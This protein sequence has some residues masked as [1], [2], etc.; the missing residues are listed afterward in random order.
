MSNPS[1]APRESTIA[2]DF[3]K[4]MPDAFCPFMY[5]A[6]AEG[7]ERNAWQ[8]HCDG[9]RDPG[10][11]QKRTD[12][13]D[14]T[15]EEPFSLPREWVC[16]KE[17]GATT[18][19]IFALAKGGRLSTRPRTALARDILNV[20]YALLPKDIRKAVADKAV[21]LVLADG[22]VEHAVGRLSKA[23]PQKGDTILRPITEMEAKIVWREEVGDLLVDEP[24]FR[25]YTKTN[26]TRLPFFAE[27]EGDRAVKMNMHASNGYPVLGTMSDA[28]AR[29]KVAA[30]SEL[31]RNE[32]MEA[33]KGDQVDGVERWFR[34][35]EKER[36]WLVACQGK[37][38]GDY[39]TQEKVRNDMLRFYA[40]LPR[41]MAVNIQT[42]TQVV[43]ELSASIL[44]PGFGTRS[45]SGLAMNKGGAARL[46]AKL[47]KILDRD[48]AAHVRM[49]DDSWV[50]VRVGNRIL[51]FALDG[52][53]FDL[54]QNGQL[55]LEV[56]KQVRRTVS[57]IDA[58]AAQLQYAYF[59]QRLITLVGRMVRTFKHGG[60]SGMSLQ[61][62]VNGTIMGTAIRRTVFALDDLG[63]EELSE[64]NVN[65][66]IQ[67]I[68]REM[69]IVIKVEQFSNTRLPDNLIN[70]NPIAEVLKRQKFLFLGYNFYNENGVISVHTDLPRSMA[71]SR[72]PTLKWV[73]QGGLEAL[74]LGRFASTLLAWGRPTEELVPAFTAIKEDVERRITAYILE[75]GDFNNELLR[76][77]AQIGVQEGL[78][79]QTLSSL[80]GVLRALQRGWDDNWLGI[81]M[82]DSPARDYNLDIVA[83]AF[84]IEKTLRDRSAT[85]EEE[86]IS[87]ESVYEMINERKAAYENRTAVASRRPTKKTDGRNPNTKVFGPPKAPRPRA[88][89][90][91]HENAEW[92]RGDNRGQDAQDAAEEQADQI[93][94]VQE[95][96]DDW[97]LSHSTRLNDSD[98][99]IVV[100][101]AEDMESDRFGEELVGRELEEYLDNNRMYI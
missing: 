2:V 48:D 55:T 99:R 42:A 8:L 19:P 13:L 66:I 70:A 85:F 5:E 51:M 77:A 27:H 3:T 90:R 44:S 83:D 23:F 80:S 62:K 78:D 82:P 12:N 4:Y 35:Q 76:W 43:D 40:C 14:W 87:R 16:D 37:A 75:K 96:L 91:T 92:V 10:T 98:S 94:Q 36:A 86:R 1:R 49:G 81:Q 47:E 68:G 54:T 63:E 97:A 88:S 29:V 34:K 32:L 53:N 67:K 30:L 20:A 46:V 65:A 84:S 9:L 95:R 39:A 28:D 71:Q 100:F 52:S 60:L 72:Y 11:V 93:A 79:E 18:K 56:H 25:A 31:V 38:K 74:E 41:H 7:Q 101:S 17:V 73:P 26:K 6:P 69:G 21:D 57:L 50:I 15:I 24:M 45:A 61:P 89:E 22:G 58:V 33:Y 59:R 64:H